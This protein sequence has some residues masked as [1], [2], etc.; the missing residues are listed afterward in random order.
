MTAL[1]RRHGSELGDGVHVARGPLFSGKDAKLRPPHPVWIVDVY[2]ASAPPKLLVRLAFDIFQ[3]VGMRRAVEED[4][5]GQVWRPGPETG[6]WRRP[7]PFRPPCGRSRRRASRRRTEAPPQAP[8][9]P[10]PPRRPARPR[11]CRLRYRCGRSGIR[12]FRIAFE[13]AHRQLSGSPDIDGAQEDDEHGHG[14][15]PAGGTF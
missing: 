8:L 12:P 5:E 15:Q 9:W 7:W 4:G 14:A 3:C 6:C 2:L 11:H 13:V 1:F 10:R